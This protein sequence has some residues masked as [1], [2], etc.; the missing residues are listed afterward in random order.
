MNG[1]SVF[2]GNSNP[3]LAKEIC[4]NLGTS[5]G[6]V[7]VGRFSDGEIKVEL[8]ENVRGKHCYVVQ[9]ISYHPNDN[10]M[11]LLFLI[12]AIRRSSA[13]EITAVIPY[14]GYARQDRRPRSARVPISAK[15]VADMITTAGVDRVLTVDLHSEQTQGFFGIPLDN[16][17]AMNHFVEYI[18]RE[19][20]MN[21]HKPDD[22]VSV[23]PDIGGVVRARALAT[24]LGLDLAIVD[25]RRPRPN[26][27]Q[28]MHIIGDIKDKTCLIIDDI[29]DTAGTLCNTA[30]ALKERGAKEVHAFITHGVLSG[31]ALGRIEKSSIDRLVISNSIDFEQTLKG[32]SH[33]TSV[34][35]VTHRD[36]LN[37]IKI[38][39]IADILAESMRRIHHGESLSAIYKR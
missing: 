3:D 29:I 17:Y 35:D 30:D 37:K 39:S 9:S 11:E 32:F 23:S 27:S 38:V 21:G 2:T 8:N 15:L 25:K 36:A 12:D 5:L 4:N 16:I 1:L 6:D 10:L 18:K 26:E 24:S 20:L 28:V 22:F 33:L 19:Y 13:S 31:P 34:D 7:T 14:F